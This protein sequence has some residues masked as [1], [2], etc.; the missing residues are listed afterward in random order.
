[1]AS[2]KE[3]LKVIRMRPGMTGLIALAFG[4]TLLSYPLSTFL[5]V[6]GKDI[7]HGS[8]MT[9]TMLLSTYGAGSV[10]GA[11]LVAGARS[12]KGNGRNALLV[13]VVLGAL[14][15]MFAISRNLVLSVVVL[16]A[17]G[18]AL[19]IVFALN[20]SLVQI[21]VT[22]GLR[23]RV[24]SVYNVAFRGGMPIGSVLCGV[25][26]K[27]TS[28]PAIIAANGVLVCAFALYF[29]LVERKVAKM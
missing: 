4:L 27:Q 11:L 28:A 15:S 3:G 19:I 23:G 7:F 9:F 16:F 18:I 17:T 13:M 25:L 10:V 26:I 8:S 14:I 12:Q 21:Y 20:S 22:D 29:L 5:P 1:M 6:F 24:L 2:M